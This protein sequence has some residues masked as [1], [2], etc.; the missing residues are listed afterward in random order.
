M[1]EMIPIGSPH[2]ACVRVLTRSL[3]RSLDDELLL[4][5]QNPIWL[6]GWLEP[7]PDLAVVRAHDYRESLPGPEDVLRADAVLGED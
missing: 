3:G 4:D 5:V 1:V 7:Q 2:A 6:N